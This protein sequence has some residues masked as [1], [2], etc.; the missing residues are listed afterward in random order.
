MELWLDFSDK[1]ITP[2]AGMALL[3]RMLDH[4]GWDDAL[5]AVKLP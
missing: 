1:Q 3:K 4:I 5:R 2:W